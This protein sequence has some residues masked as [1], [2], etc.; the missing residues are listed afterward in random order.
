METKLARF[1]SYLF[2][3]LFIPVYAYIWLTF[4]PL[5]MNHRAPISAG[6]IAVVVT[7]LLTALIPGLL[8]MMLRRMKYID[9]IEQILPKSRILPLALIFIWYVACFFLFRYLGF[10][11]AFLF[12]I[13]LAILALSISMVMNLFYPIS[14]HATAWG[15]MTGG[16]ILFTMKMWVNAPLIVSACLLISGVVGYARLKLNAHSPS[17]VYTGWIVGAITVLAVYLFR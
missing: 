13:I 6:W 5:V 11:N 16:M 10:P 15:V 8:M 14:L 1:I 4:S 9:S 17:Q 7:G 3:P 12:I 2:H